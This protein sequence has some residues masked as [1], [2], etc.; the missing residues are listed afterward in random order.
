M[1]HLLATYKKFLDSINTDPLVT[2]GE[3]VLDGLINS[4]MIGMALHKNH[5]EIV[6]ANNTFKK[7]IN[8]SNVPLPATLWLNQLTPKEYRAHDLAVIHSLKTQTTSASYEK[9]LL[10]LDNSR[11]NVIVSHTLLR[12]KTKIFLSIFLDISKG[13]RL[14]QLKNDFISIASHELKTPLTSMR[15]YTQLLQK[16]D[17]PE[18]VASYLKKMI[19]LIDRQNYLINELLDLSKIESESFE[20][21]L[22]EFDI[23]NLITQVVDEFK[24]QFPE[25]TLCY[26]GGTPQKIMADRNR[27]RQVVN[28]LVTNAIKYS[29]AKSPIHIELKRAEEGMRVAVK[30]NGV[31][32]KVADRKKVFTRYARIHTTNVQGLGL[33]LFISRNIVKK[34]GGDIGIST[35]KPKGSVFFFT[36]PLSTS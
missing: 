7:L 13:K 24:V 34:H 31:G 1:K 14:E 35:N 19:G 12:A 23:N 5:R 4:G 20:I 32:I 25:R 3:S 9:M 11:V 28:N 29:P 16:Q 6:W 2:L 26:S 18:E 21:A 30:D 17:H 36:L 22:E 33:G 15:A 27:I 8:P 10:T